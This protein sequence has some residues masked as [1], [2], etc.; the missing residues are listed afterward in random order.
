MA[1]LGEELWVKM[2]ARH[3]NFRQRL[4]ETLLE[5]K[6]ILNAVTRK[7][8]SMV[9]KKLYEHLQKAEREMFGRA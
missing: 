1:G 9:R 2:K 6:E 5:H 3:V 7:D 8:G 4:R